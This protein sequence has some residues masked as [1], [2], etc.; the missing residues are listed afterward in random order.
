MWINV[1]LCLSGSFPLL[2]CYM[3]SSLYPNITLEEKVTVS[4]AEA[5]AGYR[6]GVP[7]DL[8]PPVADDSALLVI[9]YK[10]DMK[11]PIYSYDVRDT[12]AEKAR[13]WS[14]VSVL[15]GRAVFRPDTDPAQLTLNPVKAA[16]VGMY[17][18]RVDFRKSPTRNAKVNL[19]VILP[20]ERITIVNDKGE[21]VEDR[22][23]GPFNEGASVNITCVSTGGRPL[24]RL[25][26]WRAG[27]L[28]D[29]SYEVLSERRVRNTLHLEGLGR[30]SLHETYT[31]QASNNNQ[32]YPLSSN[33]TIKMNLKPLWVKILG[34][35]R[36][37]SADQRY[38]VSC[39]AVGGRPAPRITW[40]KGSS[41]L[42]TS[43]QSTTKDENITISSLT[44][45][46]SMEDSGKFLT[47]RVG[48]TPHIVEDGWKLNIHHVPVVTLELGNSLN[49]S[50]IVEGMDVIFE[51]NIKSNPWVYK[52]AWRHRGETLHNNAG[53]GMFLVN[54][55]SLFLQSV[56][57]ERAGLYTCVASNP[58]GDGESNPIFLDVKYAPVCQTTHTQPLGVAR[59]EVARVQCE[60]EAN[61]S[62]V[63]FTW[64]LNSS[65]GG[66]ELSGSQV[67]S[68]RTRSVATYTPRSLEEYGTL[69]CLG[70]NDV[71]VIRA[72]C[73]F[74]IFPAGKPDGLSNCSIANQ[75]SDSLQIECESGFDGGLPQEFYIEVFTA[76]RK[77][78]VRNITS[79]EPWFRVEGLEEGISFDINM[80]AFNSK[81][82]SD[83]T[84][85]HAYAV[86]TA[87]RHMST[88]GITPVIVTLTPLVGAILGLVAT[89]LAVTLGI[90]LALRQR[91]RKRQQAKK[92][93]IESSKQISDSQDSLEK[94]PDLIPHNTDYQ[95]TEKAVLEK[96][97]SLFTVPLKP[98]ITISTEESDATDVSCTHTKLLPEFT[99][100]SDCTMLQTSLD[101]TFRDFKS[102]LMPITCPM[103]PQTPVT[104]ERSTIVTTATRF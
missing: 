39:E 53:S 41:Q 75:T 1:L 2:S 11:K 17:R 24:P 38:E 94:N 20:P 55:Q 87:E 19:T 26:W 89:L 63:T 45:V 14:E 74:V 31:C 78:L 47:C 18:C 95:C 97:S 16:D 4:D 34:D 54:N 36:P 67:T 52:V 25:T 86:K 22:F 49:L 48:S 77:V 98:P 68:D 84:M 85:L 28:V 13:H 82:R 93:S 56:S 101:T 32:V 104:S 51:C 64:R 21:P 5:V 102:S 50:S 10:N 73:A 61:P 9:W 62:D 66:V 29:D 76:Q 92:H 3:I 44:F 42:K 100:I 71:G 99:S 103:V 27:E 57:R 35:N 6:A 70:S 12:V 65:A 69:L 72:P 40:W 33:L 8:S 30:R 58:E 59:Y 37:F 90:L 46:P 88:T 83:V 79:K 96:N 81:G 80:Y 43:R 91:Q 7:C 60:V 23:L 15:S